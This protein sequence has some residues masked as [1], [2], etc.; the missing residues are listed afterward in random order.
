[1]TY[2]EAETLSRMG[3]DPIEQPVA[4]GGAA[5]DRVK[6]IARSDTGAPLAVMGAEYGVLA[7]RDAFRDWL[8]AAFGDG[9]AVVETAGVLD[10]GRRLFMSA[11]LPGDFRPIGTRGDG[12]DLFLSLITSHDG[13]ISGTAL[14][15]PIRPVC[16]NTIRAA[17]RSARFR[18]AVRHTPNVTA[19]ARDVASALAGIRKYH[20]TAA[21]QFSVLAER[22]MTESELHAFLTSLFPDPKREEGEMVETPVVT[23]AKRERVRELFEG[24]G[25][26]SD[27]AGRTAWGALNAVTQFVDREQGRACGVDRLA[28]SLF[29]NEAQDTRD[30]ALTLLVGGAA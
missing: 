28:R 20:E 23:R 25:D 12:V 15:S 22:Q 16:S 9:A 19:N 5:F 29:S 6:G 11:R 8:S 13:S 18:Y 21:A 7:H 10:G 27:L 1:M 2:Q 14:A 24:E 3:W 26:G 4:V 30:R 17:L